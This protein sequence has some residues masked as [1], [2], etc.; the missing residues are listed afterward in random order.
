MVDTAEFKVDGMEPSD[1]VHPVNSE[2]ISAYL[3]EAT[4][5]G[6]A[7]IPWGGGTRMHIG[8]L[9]KRYDTA[10]DLTG[11]V[12]GF[13]HFAGDMVCIA[14]AGMRVNDVQRELIK[15]NQRLPF[16]VSH[17]REATIGGS[18]A[19]NAPGRL[20][21]AFGGMREWVIGMEVVMSDGRIV[22]SGSRV[23]KSVQGFDMHKLHIGAFGSLGIIT[24]AAFKLVPMPI[25][26]ASIRIA[27]SESQQAK[28]FAAALFNGI[29]LPESAE[30]RME[31]NGKGSINI[32][33]TGGKRSLSR[34]I[35]RIREISVSLTLSSEV[36]ESK[37]GEEDTQEKGFVASS[38]QI[39]AILPPLSVTEFLGSFVED[40][41]IRDKRAEFSALADI[42]FGSVQVCFAQTAQTD[43]LDHKGIIDSFM[44]LASSFGGVTLIELCPIHIKSEMDVFGSTHQGMDIMRNLK[45]RFDPVDT[46]NHGR[47][48]GRM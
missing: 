17:P 4:R 12:Q 37:D 43:R 15:R 1:I 35:D 46:M 30:L 38:I 2:E 5:K 42:L 6:I 18:L 28:M 34:M 41:F 9:P 40:V 33:L 19:S 11:V 21:G 32:E 26:R 3:T 16:Q 23:V 13:K 25:S 14:P 20:E 45:S 39:R 47:F 31:A 10:M 48:V 29:F 44:S 8:N 24:K 27:F 7:V 22:K 36:V